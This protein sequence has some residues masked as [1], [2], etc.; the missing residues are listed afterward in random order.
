MKCSDFN[1]KG[2]GRW[3]NRGAD[4]YFM[5]AMLKWDAYEIF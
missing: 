4:Q 1:E 2:K 5:G 3:R